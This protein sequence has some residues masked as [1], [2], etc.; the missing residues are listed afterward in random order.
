MNLEVGTQL[1]EY[2]IL[3][4]IGQGSYGVVFEAEHAITRRVDAVK[5]MHDAGASSADEEQRFLR[6]IQAQA[7][8]QHLNIATVYGAFRTPWGLALAMELVR[9]K[10]L[11]TVLEAGPLPTQVAIGYILAVLDGLSCAERLGIIHRDVKPDNI[12]ITES[13]TVKITDF[14]LAQVANSARITSSGENL[15]TPCYMSPEQAIC[16]SPADARSDVYSTAVVLYE[17]VTGRP[18]FIGTNGFAV[19]MAHQSTLPVAPAELQP[20]IGGELNRVILKALEKVPDRRFQN[21]A[22]FHAALERAEVLAGA[23]A[24]PR[25]ITRTWKIA[26]AAAAAGITLGLCGLGAWAGH[27]AMHRGAPAPAAK[28]A[29]PV[30]AP[31]APPPVVPVAAPPVLPASLSEPPAE[32]EKPP[33]PVPHRAARRVPKRGRPVFRQAAVSHLEVSRAVP[34]DSARTAASP[35]PAPA[36][37]PPPAAGPLSVTG[38]APVA[39]AVPEPV[40]PKRKNIFRRAL[41]KIFGHRE[42]PSAQAAAPKGDSTVKP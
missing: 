11:R 31:Q 14:G 15:G 25:P 17:A 36:L 5:L 35:T 32:V 33:V 28:I 1:G 12:L 20:S 24:L 26:A 29:M 7:S 18:P 22:E 4:R 8:L 41:G 37:P 21:A 19:M 6:E 2:R 27:W 23:G 38:A 34:P 10:S 16:S 30:S 13:G 39:Q 42:T 9:G 40:Q 3:S